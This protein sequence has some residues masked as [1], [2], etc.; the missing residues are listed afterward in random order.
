MATGIAL[1]LALAGCGSVRTVTVTRTVA[2]PSVPA[3]PA[4]TYTADGN[5]SPLFCRVDNPLALRFYGSLGLRDLLALGRDASPGAVTRV[6][7]R[8]NLTDPQTCSVYALASRAEHWHFG[9]QPLP[10]S[11]GACP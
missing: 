8:H 11:A 1:A 3:C 10:P 4:P 7:E 9:I 5:L 2:A 6:L